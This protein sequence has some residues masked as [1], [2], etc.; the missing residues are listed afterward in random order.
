MLSFEIRNVALP[1]F[2]AALFF[3]AAGTSLAED[4]TPTPTATPAST[5]QSSNVQDCKDNNVSVG[6]CPAFLQ[7]KLSD[8]QGQGKTL[9]SQI[10]AADTQIKLS[11][12][13]IQSTQYQIEELE[14]DI[15]ITKTKISSS[16]GDLER[17]S[18]AFLGRAKAVYQ[19]GTVDPWQVLLTASNLD[20]FFMRLKYL[21]IVQLFDKRNIYAAEQAKV[22]YANQQEILED[23]KQEQEALSKKLEAFTEQLNQDKDQKKKLLAETQGSEAN[24]QRLLSQARAQLE[25]F[26]NFTTTQGGASILSGQT[27]CDDWGCYY[28]QR[29]SQWGNQ[30][31]NGTQYTLASDGCLVTSMAMVYTHYGNRGVTPATINSNPGNFASYYPAY[32]LKRISAEGKTTDR[33]YSEVDAVLSAGNPL[34]VGISYDGGGLAD[35]FVVFRSGS[36]GNYYM[37][38]PFTPG[39][40]NISYQERYPGVRIVSYEKVVF[41]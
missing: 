16:E 24:Y 35:H 4:P 34:V 30:S 33:V 38:D 26:R 40:K 11:E 20:N 8:V 41:L 9:S 36:N 3:S 25:G 23:K 10:A 19:V 15:D 5:S 7:K 27:S 21:K 31:L 14:D 18:Y 39:G 1:F 12:A 2:I 13:K 32:L 17:T 22:N 6:D 29:D 28:N 37:N